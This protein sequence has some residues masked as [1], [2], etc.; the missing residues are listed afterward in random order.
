MSDRDWETWHGMNG[1]WYAKLVK[2]SP[3][4][5]VE[6]PLEDLPAAIDQAERELDEGTYWPN[7]L[8]ER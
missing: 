1:N 6:A 4:V 2:S 7:R 3:P 8:R 5:T